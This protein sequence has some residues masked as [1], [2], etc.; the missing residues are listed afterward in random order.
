MNRSTL[1]SQFI[2]SFFVVSECIALGWLLWTEDLT[3]PAFLLLGAVGLIVSTGAAF[4]NWPVGCLSVIVL[5]SAMPRYTTSVFG[6]H[7]RAEHLAI[8]LVLLCVSVQAA[9]HRIHGIRPLH[10]FDYLLGCYVGANFLSSILTSPVPRM[11]L[12]WAVLN[13]LVI[14]PYFLLRYL[15]RDEHSIQK[16]MQILLLVGVCE[17]AFGILC[18]LSNRLFETGVGVDVEQ[19]GFIPGTHG[20]QYEA[21]LFG[22]YTAC[23]GVMCLAMYFLGQRARRAFYGFGFSICLLAAFVSLAR[24]VML[25]IPVAAL[26]VLWFAVRSGRAQFRTLVRVA[27]GATVVLL[28]MSPFLLSFIVERFSSID[29]NEL[30]QDNTAVNRL[31]QTAVAV[32]DVRVHPILGMGTSSFQ[33]VFDWDDLGMPGMKGDTDEG[34]WISNSPLR[35]LHD[36][37]VVGLAVFMFFI[38][39]LISAIRKALRAAPEPERAAIIAL[40]AGLLLYA[41]TFQA[42]EATMLSFTWVHIGLLAAT[43]VGVQKR[44]QEDTADPA[45]Q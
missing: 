19:Y 16:A 29:L 6:L 17:A 26:F 32:D 38:G 8:G 5:A 34:G 2:R 1:Q 42:T 21:N 15:V 44:R 35:I 28:I 43:V 25:A 12:R 10:P 4:W 7:V 9:K 22:S 40:S 31:V 30:A 39:F 33:L 13:T 3:G 36:T 23:C 37:G 24:S 45:F 20:T 11:T 18:F 14:L 27:T 41:I